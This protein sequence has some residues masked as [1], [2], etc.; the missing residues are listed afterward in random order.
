MHARACT[1]WTMHDQSPKQPKPGTRALPI[2][3]ALQHPTPQGKGQ[4]W[5][6]FQPCLFCD[7]GQLTFPIWA[8]IFPME[9][10]LITSLSWM[11][12]K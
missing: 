8:S 2:P 9:T 6:Q 4:G 12:N 11:R 3:G 1:S 10:E 7:L 5:V